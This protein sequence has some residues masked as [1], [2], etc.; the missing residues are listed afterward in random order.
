MS[1]LIS[2]AVLQKDVGSTFQK[3]EKF[4][5]EEDRNLNEQCPACKSVLYPQGRCFICLACGVVHLRRC[6]KEKV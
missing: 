1:R 6:L 3:V 2:E 5:T 4:Q